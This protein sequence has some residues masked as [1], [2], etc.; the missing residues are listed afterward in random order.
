MQKRFLFI[1]FFTFILTGGLLCLA[2]CHQSASPGGETS[3]STGNISN[4]TV[5]Y[6]IKY[7]VGNGINPRSNPGSYTADDEITLAAP[8]CQGYVFAGWKGTDLDGATA[9]VT[10][11]A[12]STG[13]REYYAVWERN[14]NIIVDKT[15][16]KPSNADD[17]IEALTGNI[18]LPTPVDTGERGENIFAV[19]TVYTD[20][21]TDGIKDNVYTYGLHLTMDLPDNKSF[22]SNR[23]TGY[24]VYAVL[25]ASGKAHFFVE[26]TDPDIVINDELWASKWWH[27]DSWQMYI[28]YGN[29]GFTNQLWTFAADAGRKYRK[30]NP[31]EWKVVMTEKGF[32]VEFAFDNDGSPFMDGDEIGFGFYYNDCTSY[33]SLNSY[34]KHTLKTSSAKNPVTSQYANPDPAIQDALRFSSDSATGKETGPSSAT[35]EKTGDM[36]TDII[37][38]ASDAV[39]LYGENA[40]AYTVLKAEAVCNMLRKYTGKSIKSGYEAGG[41]T[42]YEYEILIGLTTRDESRAAI[43]IFGYNEYAVTISENRITVSGW[44]E[45]ALNKAVLAFYACLEYVRDGGKTGG[46]ES[47][48]SGCLDNIPGVNV[49]KLD[50]L[51]TVTDAGDGA[52]LLLSVNSSEEAFEA[53]YNALTAVGYTLHTENRMSTVLCRTYYDDMAVINMTYCSMDK[54]L[55][56]VVEP[57]TGTTLP[58]I[59]TPQYTPASDSSV[60]QVAPCNMCYILKLDNGELIVI[61]SGNNGTQNYIYEQ[62]KKLSENEKPVVAAWIFTHF[63]QDHIGGFIDFVSSGYC[64]KATVKSVIYSFP[65][66]QVLDTASSNDLSNISKWNGVIKSSGATVYKARTGQK[67]YI[68]NA[69]VEM[70]FTYEDLMPFFVYGD[71]TNNTSLIFTV[72]ICGQKL[73]FLGDATNHSTKLTAQRFTTYL[74]SDFV[75]LAHHGLGD[76]GTYEGIYRYA[77]ANW[78]LYPWS[79]YS[80]GAAEKYACQ[81]AKKYFLR[82]ETTITLPLPYNP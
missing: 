76:G 7:N 40:S 81:I 14:T 51:T 72:S 30:E 54:S 12:G 32:N 29:R 23:T 57:K 37:S 39:V 34:V 62:M 45:D 16:P 4:E 82:G 70:L 27:C 63:H 10:I 6:Q 44:T 68:G 48:Y 52:Y 1:M 46:L 67:Y 31:S 36:I 53:Y 8:V 56:V 55:R 59:S 13:V 69:E 35:P 43:D 22:Y 71:T 38:G 49:P 19:K 26:V 60:T 15:Q 42:E 61:D 58:A 50:A 5:I 74:A 78:V 9:R 65:E 79:T 66:A 17:N 80:P 3:G 21:A 11:P 25:D 64:S 47:C 18:P 41:K 77:G 73:L 28:D 24:E 33:K 75:Q 20:I 2:G